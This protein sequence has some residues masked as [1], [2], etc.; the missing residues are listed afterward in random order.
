MPLDAQSVV[1][2]AESILIVGA[3]GGVGGFAVQFANQI[4]AKVTAVASE[5]NH[6]YLH[7][8]GAENTVCYTKD[9]YDEQIQRIYP[10]GADV[11]F[12]LVGGDSLKSAVNYVKGNG[13][14]VSITEDPQP[15]RPSDKDI[16]SHFVFVEPNVKQ[17][18]HI[19]EMV[20]AGKLKT[21]I[22]S[23]YALSDI[24]KAHT[25]MET[26]HTLGKIVLNIN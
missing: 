1:S 11:V 13:K 18:D 5:K 7:D 2:L 22:S 12:D 21:H 17:L 3:S 6:A 19:R 15:H 23:I 14:I 26:G 10:S 4:G 9:D 8:L 24:E 16:Q 20:D 25:E